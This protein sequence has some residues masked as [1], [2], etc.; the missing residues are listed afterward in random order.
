MARLRKNQDEI[1]GQD[2]FLDIVAN[3]VG[4]MIILVMVV[5]A[6]AKNAMVIAGSHLPKPSLTKTS[7]EAEVANAKGIADQVEADFR[8]IESQIGRQE[9]ELAYR[10]EERNRVQM[11]VMHAERLL[12]D[13][14]QL[15]DESQRNAFDHQ[16]EI[17]AAQSELNEIRQGLGHLENSTVQNA[18]IEHLP[19]PMAKTVFG[20]EIHLRLYAGKIAYV[21]WDEFVL[22][23]K[24]DAPRKASRLREQAEYTD[25]IGP[26]G[27]FW[28]RY[29]LKRESQ[30]L[31][32][33][34]GVAV[35][36]TIALDRFVLLPE[37]EI[38]GESVEEALAQGSQLNLLLANH[39]PSAT[40][41]TIWTYPDSFQQF[42]QLKRALYERGYVTAA[43]PLPNDHPIG[44]SPDGTRSAAQ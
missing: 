16:K 10:E 43:R 26:L 24:E 28:M 31:Q 9:V 27:G 11:L 34:T 3:L 23:L 14:R 35:Q 33:K 7:I 17:I 6:R 37:S 12:A 2:S 32:G 13:Q 19:T 29:T 1:V 42:R 41:I 39:R 40:T 30:V 4:I 18:I 38:V 25:T 36:Q 22:R 21:P 5:G 15:L 20:H 8:R 44:G